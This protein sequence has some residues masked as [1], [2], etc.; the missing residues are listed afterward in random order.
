[1]EKETLVA[2]TNVDSLFGCWDIDYFYRFFAPCPDCVPAFLKLMKNTWEKW[3]VLS[4]KIGNFQ[5]GLF[6]SILYCVI[7]VPVGLIS[8]LF[9]DYFK[10][11]SFPVWEEW[12]DNSSILTRLKE[13]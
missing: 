8:S 9:N 4:K 6:F 11:K 12:I 10:I 7:I 3:K 2:N 13:N 1:M 5:L